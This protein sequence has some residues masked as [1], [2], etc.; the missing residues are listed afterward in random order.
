MY[1]YYNMS[2]SNGTNSFARSLNGIITYD[3]GAGTVIQN[4]TV[5]TEK[6]AINSIEASNL[7]TDCNIWQ[8]N[9]GT[10]YYSSFASGPINFGVSSTG[11]INI[12]PAAGIISEGNLSIGSSS[13]LSGN[14]VLGA[15]ST[16]GKLKFQT[17][18]T[19]VL[20]QPTT[21][22]GVVNKIYADTN[23]S[24]LL[25]GLNTWTGTSNKFNNVIYA[26][27]ISP[28]TSTGYLTIGGSTSPNTY[29]Q[30]IRAYFC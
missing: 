14:I 19:E 25:A 24:N 1:N 26:S 11:N 12:G 29:F 3:D 23:I 7:T 16:T 20:S 17:P 4:G 22:N 27:L 30:C 21:S 5:K 28:L 13:G 10:T 8:R 15:P 18:I 9:S 2:N 6:L